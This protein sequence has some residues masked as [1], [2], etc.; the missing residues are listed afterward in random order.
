MTKQ[1][2]CRLIT[3]LAMIAVLG[4]YALAQ[5]KNALPELSVAGVKLADR[6]SAKAF[7]SGYS[8]RKT[9]DGRAVYYFYNE[10]GT[11]VMKLTAASAE[12]P[13]FITEIEVFAV[14]KSYQTEHYVAD[15]LG[16]FSTESNIFIGFKQSASSLLFGTSNKTGPKEI[17]RKKKR[18][19][20]QKGE[21]R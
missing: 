8:A 15:D 7:L 4:F 12:E 2:Y 21:D 11:Q 14:G 1:R 18:C 16:V 9:D 19:A 17:V 3:C 5:E 6:E 20:E 13:Y 10:Y